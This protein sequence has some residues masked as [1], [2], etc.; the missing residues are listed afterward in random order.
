[1]QPLVEAEQMPQNYDAVA[2]TSENNTHDSIPDSPPDDAP[3]PS[4]RY[5]DSA[6]CCFNMDTRKAS[7]NRTDIALPKSYLSKS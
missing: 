1:M 3:V 6:M 2:A 5:I 7:L 4:G